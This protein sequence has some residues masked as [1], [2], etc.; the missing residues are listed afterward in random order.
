MAHTL[1]DP[2]LLGAIRAEIS[3]VVQHSKSLSTLHSDLTR[4]KLLS[5]VYHETLRLVDS[6][7]SL[8]ELTQPATSAL[9]EPLPAG[10]TLLLAH[11]QL[12]T[13]TTGWGPNANAFDAARFVDNEALLRSK[14]YTPFGG[15][16]MLCPGRFMARGEI[17]VFLAV[18]ISRFNVT[19]LSE[20][21]RLDTKS[22]A[23]AG[24]LGIKEGDD[25]LLKLEKRKDN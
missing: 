17:L 13:S 15:G 19:T 24:I 21:P 1:R 18:L 16:A 7:I 2:N 23:G 8:R 3:P 4:C 14:S 12:L 10:V 25:Y 20:F 11:R 5:S 9:G 22:G 6:P